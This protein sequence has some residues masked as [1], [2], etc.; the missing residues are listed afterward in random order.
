[1]RG[2]PLMLF[3]ALALTASGT[4]AQPTVNSGALD[5]LPQ[6]PAPRPRPA[7]R[8]TPPRPPARPE[9][10][11]PAPARPAPA[12]IPRPPAVPVAP[13]AIAAIPPAVAVPTQR[14]AEPPPI[15]VAADAPGAAT[16]MP[17]GLRATFGTDRSDLNAVTEGAIRAFARPLRGTEQAI[18]V[19]AYATGH[20][21]DP[22]TPRRLSLARALAARAVLINEG[23][24]STRIYVRALGPTASDGPPDRVDLTTAAG[25][26][27]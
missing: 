16:P 23:I 22:S 9:A 4:A 27:P 2:P 26:R 10:T 13:P 17:G 8:P 20:I 15:P 12:A 11:R 18:N 25:A 7:P 5:A 24:V 6:T 21:D 14:P 19:L 3:A 1:M